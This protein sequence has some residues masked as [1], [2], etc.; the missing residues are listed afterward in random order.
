[1]E[2]GRVMKVMHE[3]MSK[4][5]LLRGKE[6]NS[7]QTLFNEILADLISTCIGLNFGYVG[8]FKKTLLGGTST[9]YT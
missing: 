5:I 6:I 4:N 1:M 3:V 2:I 8:I 7:C 9:P